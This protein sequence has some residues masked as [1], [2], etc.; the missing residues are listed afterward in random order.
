M[1]L[2]YFYV[3]Y[4]KHK[5][6]S[7]LNKLE[8]NSVNFVNAFSINFD[9]E[10]NG[11]YIGTKKVIDKDDGVIALVSITVSELSPNSEMVFATATIKNQYAT[12]M[13][14]LRALGNGFMAILTSMLKSMSGTVL[15]YTDDTGCTSYQY[16]MARITVPEEH[17]RSREKI[18]AYVQEDIKMIVIEGINDSWRRSIKS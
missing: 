7:M 12:S 1:L 6:G 8:F 10:T 17:S 2:F 9:D 5:G 3:H 11:F 15:N 16:V 18:I 4:I 13:R 14:R